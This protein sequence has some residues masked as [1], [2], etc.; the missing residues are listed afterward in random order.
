[1]INHSKTKQTGA[2]AV[3]QVGC[4]H[5]I[6]HRVIQIQN[7]NISTFHKYFTISTTVWFLRKEEK[8][9]KKIGLQD[10]I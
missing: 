9:T 10:Y 6:F 4:I 1:M 2:K 8:G 7:Q 3:M 5:Y